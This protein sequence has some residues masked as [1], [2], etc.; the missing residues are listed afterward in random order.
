[1]S[2]RTPREEATA[3]RLAFLLAVAERERNEADAERD[4]A[5]E[6]LRQWLISE[7]VEL[8]D[9]TVAFLAEL[10]SRDV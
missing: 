4:R 2:D 9:E 3:D 10:E 8:E 1:M 5:V 7:A 6:L